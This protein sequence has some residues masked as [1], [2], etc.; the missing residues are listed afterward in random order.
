M[1]FISKGGIFMIPILLVSIAAVALILERIYTFW[2]RYRMDEESFLKSI[3]HM[4]DQRRHHQRD[5][6]CVV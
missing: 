4:V 2:L 5:P 1:E 6:R 3:F